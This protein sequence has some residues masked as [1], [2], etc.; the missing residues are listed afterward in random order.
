MRPVVR[1]SLEAGLLLV[2]SFVEDI[3]RV[4]PTPESARAAEGDWDT[5]VRQL[6][7]RALANL[8]PLREILGGDFVSDWLGRRDQRRLLTLA[9]P[10]VGELRAVTGRL[11]TLAYG[12]WRPG[13]PSWR[14]VR[15]EFLDRINWWNRIFLAAHL[16]DHEMPALLVELIR[17]APSRPGSCVA[18]FLN[19]IV[20]RRPSAGPNTARW[21]YSARK[22]FSIKS[23][24][25]CWRTSRSTS[26]KGAVCRL[27]IEY[28]PPGP[29]YH[30]ML[31]RNSGTAGCTPAGHGLK[32]LNDKLTP[33]GGS[34]TGQVL[35]E[36]EWT[37]A[38]TATLPL[39]HG[40]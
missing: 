22:S 12:P 27:H 40:R 21:R 15:G 32:A 11:H 4:K 16:T 8:P 20:L 19:P 28:K 9:R 17:S 7:E 2:R 1:H 30:A 26:V 14:A 35:T 31:V 34:L 25:M 3:E 29:R 6:E 23:S 18:R 5:C 37:F 38:A 36:D 13:D 10:D 33:F 24:P 39:W